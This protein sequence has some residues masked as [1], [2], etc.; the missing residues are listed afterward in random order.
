MADAPL[1]VVLRQV[2][3]MAAGEGLADTTDGQLLERFRARREEAAFAALLHRHGPMVLAVARRVLRQ[4]Q[5]AEDVFQATFLLLA[6]KAGSIHKRESVGSWLHGVAYRLAAEARGQ[7]ARRQARERARAMRQNQTSP[8]G[9]WQELEEVL[10]RALARLPEK[11]REAVVLCCLEGKTQEEAARHL[12][13]PL[14]TVRSRLARG[15]ELLRK[16]LA[17]GGVPLSAAALATF[18]AA[19][20]APAAVPAAALRGAARAALQAAAGKA[21]TAAVP[22]RAVALLAGGRRAVGMTRAKAV[23]LL[24]ALSALAA[25]AGV[26]ALQA[27]PAKGPPPAGESG[28]KARAEAPAPAADGEERE[29]TDAD[30]APLPAGALARLGTLRFRHKFDVTHAVFSRDGKALIAADR[31]GLILFWDAE[32]GKEL[33]R[34]L[35]LDD[36]ALALAVSP[37]GKTLAAACHRSM[38]LWD[39]AA[40]KLLRR[41]TSPQMRS[42]LFSPDG[43]TLASHGYDSSVYLW[44][45]ATGEKRH[46][47]KGHRGAVAAFAFSPDGAQLASCSWE[48]NVVRLWD[49]AAGREVRQL[50]GQG[51]QVLAVAWSPDGK[52]VASTGNNTLCFWDPVTG[53]ERARL[54]DN[55]R[56]VP[57]PIAYLP[58]G[59]ALVGLQSNYCTA[60]LYDPATG[61]V[62]RSFT[63][64]L[65]SLGD[66]TISPDGKRVAASRGG[67]HTPELWDVAT[68]KLLGPE[69]HRQPVTCLAFTGDGEAIF[70]GSGTTEYA[71]RVWG[72]ATGKELRRLGAGDGTQGSHAL[73][74]SPDGTLLAVGTYDG[75]GFEGVSLRDPATGREV[76]RL[77]HR[78]TIRSV[79]FSADGRRLAA[80]SQEGKSVRLWDVATGLP[81]A[82][83]ATD[84]GEPN[85]AALSPDGKL[86]AA[87]GYQD[88]SVRLWSADTG[89]ELRRLQAGAHSA[90]AI[91]FS[92]DGTQLAVGGWKGTTGLWDPATGKLIRRLDDPSEQIGALAFSPDGRTLAMAGDAVRLWEVATGQLRATLSGHAGWGVA[93]C[94]LS[95]TGPV[96]ALA[97]SRDGRYLAS[98]GIDTTILT[99]DLAGPAARPTRPRLDALWADLAGGAAEAHQAVRA[100]AAAPQQAVPFLRER[101]RP[102]APLTAAD[103][104]RFDRLLADLDSDA[105]TAREKAAAEL[106]ERGAAVEPLLHRAL[107]GGPA[108]E[109]RRRLEKLVGNL[110]AQSPNRLR[111][112]RAVEALEYA[113]WAEAKR[114][115]AELAGGAPE[116]W[117]TREAQA[118]L[119]RLERR[120]PPPR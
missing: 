75:R 88:G 91:A 18:L 94:R 87:G 9:A 70:S 1:G 90:Y 116:A 67:L 22:P 120:P 115:L 119:E 56:G 19:G 24:V 12:G 65:R 97:F 46:E 66:M 111:E 59:S 106:E 84:Q 89:R 68:G 27:P 7:G 38:R 43:K 83:I 20:A 103:R 26:C 35:T 99:W 80:S 78:G 93:S 81:G 108:P 37:D 45:P 30:G 5:D 34:I 107:A 28:G 53:R 105:F 23:A 6:R 52:T 102:V 55:V 61:K 4:E 57:A 54:T 36:P 48:D 113:G 40:G 85:P 69:G 15:R 14:G 118:S 114:L 60:R 73:A 58:D 8:A 82:L 64:A 62:L 10:D 79:C 21:V 74:L 86:V 2:R 25:G 13:C 3:R 96:S 39:L 41:W 47:L 77:K 101:L 95:Y 44:G 51:R 29:R 32:T 50:K 104:A 17:A 98:G 33:R 117:L 100:L 11:Y 71:L 72:P 92:P 110:D 63:P 109:V 31:T 49:V 16:Q 76:R 42:L 112:L